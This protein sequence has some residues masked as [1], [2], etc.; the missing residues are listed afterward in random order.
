MK[1]PPSNNMGAS[2]TNAP[3]APKKNQVLIDWL[4]WTLK[5]SDPDEAIR[6]SGL[7]CMDFTQSKTGG[8]GYRSSKRSGNVVVFY[9]GS[10][11]MG[12][13]IS[14]TGQGCRQYEAL[15]STKHCW[16]QLLHTITATG[17]NITRLDLA[18][19]NVDGALDLDAV[20]SA[21]RAGEVRTLFKKG[22]TQEGI[23]LLKVKENLGKTFYLGS[24]TSRLKVRFYDKA[25]QMK[26]Q[27]HW[28]R[29]ELQLMAER[30]TE[31][32]RHILKSR[33][34]GQIAVAALNHYFTVVNLDDSNKSR[35]SVKAWW[36]AWLTTTD[37]LKLS[38]MKAL[39]SIDEVIDYAKR[40]YSAT[41]AM[42]K[43][44]LGV[45]SYHEFMRD[46][47]QIGAEKMGKRHEMILQCSNLVTELPF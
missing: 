19:D 44:Y 28:V 23:S 13:H 3:A 1:T 20:E 29:C 42:I 31:A 45:A 32:V 17:A 25:A 26:T 18:I 43:K 21:C 34:V 12:V 37:K 40:Q 24:P 11:N 8:M 4:S 22:M 35:C 14:M 46:F 30:A 7:D 47:V 5:V 15:K 36:S 10:E 6:L 9:D 33:D 38:T 27:G 2:I 16:F 41:F 39:K